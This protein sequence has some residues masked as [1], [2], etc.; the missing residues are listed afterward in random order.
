MSLT[1]FLG[2]L[3]EGLFYALL[4]MGVFISFRI[5][6]TPDLT[7]EGSYTLGVAVSAVLTVAGHPVLGLLCA[8]LAGAAAGSVT[9]LLQTKVGIHP[10]L[11]GILTMSGLY[12][13][14]TA[15]MGGKPDV[16][17]TKTTIFNKLY[18]VF[19]IN[20]QAFNRDRQAFTMAK[21]ITVL[22]VGAVLA[23][24]VLALLIWFFRTHIGLCIRATG[25]NEAMVR[26]SSINAGGMKVL[27]L[28]V[29]NGCTALAG[30]VM[31]Q[32]GGFATI[33]NGAGV[34]VV[35]LASVIIGEAIVGRRGVTVGLISAILGSVLYQCLIRL[36]TSLNIFPA[37]YLK[38]VSA[39]IVA[40]ALALPMI[41]ENLGRHHRKGGKSHA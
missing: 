18:E 3:Q 33:S 27:G 22:I 26:S 25:N 4:A 41:R 29:A 20:L 12:T 32:S 34:L 36:A 35:G 39:V 9:G 6:N 16:T 19:N 24:L 17:L 13:I 14:N 8:F 2:G 15:V 21:E 37:Y 1:M 31:T 40:I 23:L 5:L 7:T 28:A 38:L 10:I 11:A 30:G